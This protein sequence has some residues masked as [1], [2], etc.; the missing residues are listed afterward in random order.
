MFRRFLPFRVRATW[1][2]SR[3]DRVARDI[4]STLPIVPASDGLV[5]FSMIGTAVLNPYLVAV[6]SLWR[7][8]RR[9]R[10]VIL[11]DG[12][13]TEQDVRTLNRHCG[14]PEILSVAAVDTGDWPRGGCW[15]RLLAILDR[16]GDEYWVQLD[17]DTVTIGP[18]PEIAAAIDANRSFTMLG[19]EEASV[20]TLPLDQFE[21]H[22]YPGGPV[23]H[24]HVQHRIESRLG[25]LPSA[26]G[27]RYVRGCAAF[28]GFAA[29]GASRVS[30]APLIDAMGAA[31]SQ[32]TMDLWGSEQVASNLI[33]ANEP[34][35]LLLDP[36]RYLNHWNRP[37][38][39]DAA[40]VHFIGAHRHDGGAYRAAT[41]QAIAGWR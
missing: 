36:A 34:D 19:G 38:A 6:K 14:H 20:G 31:H 9:G 27:W 22:F 16:P 5:L 37:W 35:P 33:I 10:I 28:A 41:V 4:L 25:D 23:G 2:N 7:Q 30:A 29:G 8:L 13:L 17:S 39:R 21:R 26:H 40:F 1:D 12:T 18:V 11:D 15:E 3:H 32:A 24:G